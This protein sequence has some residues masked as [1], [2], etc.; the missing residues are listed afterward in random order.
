L[1]LRSD[2]I[3]IR[4]EFLFGEWFGM[5]PMRVESQ[6]HRCSFLHNAHAGV[7]TPVDATLVSFGQSKP[8]FQIQI[9]T[10]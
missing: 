6:Q 1:I 3:P 10:R 4:P 9:V 8:T 2:S 5:V 7:T